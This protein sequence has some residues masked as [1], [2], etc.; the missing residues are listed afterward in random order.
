MASPSG[1]IKMDS[2]LGPG[3]ATATDTAPPQ[4]ALLS[5]GR[6]GVVIT[7]AGS[8]YSTWR[9]LDVTRWREDATPDCWGQFCYLREP[10]E[11]PGRAARDPP[12]RRAGREKEGAFH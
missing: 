12:P 10:A 9:G 1:D 7:A 5:N 2:R 6:Y 3:C 11:G 8:G 4:V